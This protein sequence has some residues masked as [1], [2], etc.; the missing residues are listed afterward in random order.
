MSMSTSGVPRPSPLGKITVKKAVAAA[1]SAPDDAETEVDQTPTDK[2]PVRASKSAA[3]RPTGA[4]GTTGARTAGASARSAVKPGAA[5]TTKPAAEVE[6]D[7]DDDD[8]ATSARS[9]ARKAPAKASAAKTT[10][11]TATKTTGRPGGKGPTGRGPVKAAAGKAKGRR[12][13]RVNQGRNWASL[14]L[15]ITAAAVALGIIGFGTYAL[16]SRPD[17]TKWK[18]RADAIPGIV[19]YRNQNPA[20][21]QQR[22]HVQGVIQYPVNPP[23]GGNHNP[24]WQNCMGNVYTQQIAKEHAT[25]SLEHGAVW[26]AYQP[27]LPQ[28]QVAQLAS[29]INGVPFTLMAPYPGL[30]KPISLQAWGFQLKV[31]NANDPRIKDF[32]NDL[33]QNASMEP[34]AGCSGG[35]TEQGISTP[36]NLGG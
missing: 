32:I 22:N 29:Y 5:K 23:V 16:V 7:L 35:V 2:T 17:P 15:Y 28:D 26:I 19:D 8:D 21:L 14:A 24:N 31:D 36:L 4:K 12:P 1:G 6:D 20:W 30:D 27:N 11:R 9:T 10:A 18:Q 34:T 25:H 33:R 3:A 13:I